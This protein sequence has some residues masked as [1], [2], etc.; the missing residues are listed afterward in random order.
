MPI[1]PLTA[2]AR[3][4][5]A[6]LAAALLLPAAMRGGAQTPAGAT[7][8]NAIFQL[9]SVHRLHLSLTSAEWAMLQTS[10]PRNGAGTGGTDYTQADSRIV[11]IGSGFGGFFPWAH[12]DV[13]IDDAGVKAEFKNVGFRYKGNLSFQ[14]SSASAPLFANF[15]LK[16]DTY[17]ARGAWD[18]E[19]TFNLHA[20]VVDQSRTKEAVAFATFRAAGVPASRTAYAE[21]FFTVPGV[22]QDVSAGV[23]TLIEDVNNAFLK[24]VLPPGGGLLMKPEGLRG[25]IVSQGETWAPYIA[26]LRPD[27]DATPHEQQRV[28]EFANLISQTDVGLFRAKVGACL[29]VDEF[30]RFIAVNAFIAN[31]DSYLGGGHNFYF[32]LDPKDDR[33]RFLPW[34]Q[35]LA[36]GGRGNVPIGNANGMDL[37]QPYRGDQPLIYW[38]LDDPAVL[39]RY[40]AIVR[41]LAG[42]AF[43]APALLKVLD[44]VEPVAA[45]RAASPR[46]FLESRAAYVQQ[47]IAAWK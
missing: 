23:F 16:I 32:Y 41:E 2:P 26:R 5:T 19:K 39:A 9:A 36:M 15:K 8:G 45:G 29:D 1:A 18:G 42:S 14:S 7:A 30:L 3:I 43:S 11:H 38:L 12:A 35:D 10:S 44:A 24:R 28:M 13:R 25:G 37:N 47:V 17:G 33:F 6:T 22:Y 27:R 31:T 20:G 46:A 4:A 40:R 34:D 21:L